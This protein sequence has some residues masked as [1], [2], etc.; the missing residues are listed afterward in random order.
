MRA[1]RYA[2]MPERLML[3]ETRVR[4]GNKP[5]TLVSTM[6]D[7]KKV[8]ASALK[9]LYKKRWGVELNLRDIKTT[10][11]MDVLSCKTPS[12]V[13]KEIWIH[14]LA[15]N[16]IRLLMGQAANEAGREPRS[17]SFKHTLQLWLAWQCHGAPLEGEGIR[18]MLR[19]V[20]Q[21][22]VGNRPGRIEP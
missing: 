3:R 5:K 12:M 10:L 8:P 18:T 9:R 6:L 15:Y 17:I 1:E 11:G 13:P 4:E 14:L 20:A 7:G 16:L 2:S 21:N 19:L 22:T